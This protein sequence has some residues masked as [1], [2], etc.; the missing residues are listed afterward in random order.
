MA[1]AF[2]VIAVH[3]C[4]HHDGEQ[5]GSLAFQSQMCMHVCS[6]MGSSHGLHF[7]VTADHACVHHDGEKSKRA[8]FQSQLNMHVRI[9]MGS[10]QGV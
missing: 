3:V 1:G 9:M 10:R 2:P 4:M 5:A 8:T 7:S 6:M